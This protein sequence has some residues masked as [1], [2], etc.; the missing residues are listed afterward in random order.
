MV[1]A[2][3]AGS[4]RRSAVRTRTAVISR[5]KANSPIRT[6]PTTRTTATLQVAST[7]RETDRGGSASR[8]PGTP[9]TSEES[10]PGYIGNFR[11][12]N[13]VTKMPISVRNSPAGRA[14]AASLLRQTVTEFGG[15]PD[16]QPVAVERY[17][18][19]VKPESL[20][21]NPYQFSACLVQINHL[22]TA[23]RL[24]NGRFPVVGGDCLDASDQ[25]FIRAFDQIITA[26]FGDG[27]SGTFVQ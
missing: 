6:P 20:D 4:T 23:F 17:T 22:T 27:T 19:A 18:P 2:R 24:A 5:T 7:R 11:V 10:A 1:G 16:G 12:A 14:T 26:H 21:L 8:G 3:A 25:D 15:G 9:N 13:P